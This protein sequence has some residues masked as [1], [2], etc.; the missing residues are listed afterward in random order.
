MSAVFS[1]KESKLCSFGGIWLSRFTYSA[2][3]AFFQA[4]VAHKNAVDVPARLQHR[5]G[6]LHIVVRLE[7][8]FLVV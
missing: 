5:L 6:Y 2:F 8:P 4:E 7:N 3:S 1:T